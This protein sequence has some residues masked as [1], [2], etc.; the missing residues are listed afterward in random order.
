MSLADSKKK[1]AKPPTQQELKRRKC[2]EQI[3]I[4]LSCSKKAW[5]LVIKLIERELRKWTL[6]YHVGGSK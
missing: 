4:A 5:P 3:A 6:F 2:A 1:K